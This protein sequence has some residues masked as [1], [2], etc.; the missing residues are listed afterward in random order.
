MADSTSDR[1]LNMLLFAL[2]GGLA[3]ALA[4]IGIY[5]VVAYS[6]TQRRH[7]IGVRM[8]IGAQPADVMRMVLG[9]GGRLAAAGIVRGFGVGDR[10]R[11]ADPRPAVRCERDRPDHARRRRGRT[12]RR[13]AA[14]QLHPG[15]TGD[16]RRSDDGAARRVTRYFSEIPALNTVWRSRGLAGNPWY[17]RALIDYVEADVE[18]ER[19]MGFMNHLAPTP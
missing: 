1:R 16:P 4:A 2:L 3:L 7:E 11:A 19:E 5:G 14:R 9:E 13:G 10:L 12:A 8:A 6:V 17:R 18:A 15:A